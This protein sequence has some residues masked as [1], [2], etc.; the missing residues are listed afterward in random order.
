MVFV[1]D[2]EHKPLS[3]CHPA[4]ARL[5]ITSGK[6]AVWRRYPFTIILKRVISAAH[7]DP[8]RMKIDPGSKTTGLAL[9]NDVTGQVVWAAELEHRGHRIRDALLARRAIRRGRRQRHTR[10]R[11]AR[12]A[13]R[14]RGDGWLPPSLES[15]VSNVL[16]W[17]ARLRRWCRV[18]ALSLELVKFDTHLLQN[19]EISGVKYQQGELAGYEVREY[20]LEKWGRR[21]AYC[22]ATN[23]PWQVEHIVPKIRGGS[24]RVSNLTMACKPCNDA[25]G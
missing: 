17:V 2:T 6:A 24:N 16:T 11:P 20:L 14:R 12:F 15:R 13:N 4:R 3:P 23:V 21:C 25:K 8:L 7:P 9:V 18:G 5:L 10:Y 19:A 1:V 22:G